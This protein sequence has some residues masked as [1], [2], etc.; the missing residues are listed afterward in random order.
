MDPIAEYVIAEAEWI[1]A[2]A[3]A[4]FELAALNEEL[5]EYARRTAISEQRWPQA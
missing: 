3:A 4:R 5:R 1:T 2:C